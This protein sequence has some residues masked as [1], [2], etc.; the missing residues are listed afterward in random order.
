ME[1]QR[2]EKARS[3]MLSIVA[4]NP[5]GRRLVPVVLRLEAELQ[6]RQSNDAE[7]EQILKLARVA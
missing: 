1:V 3:I 2:L 4:K 7:Y 5:E 6:S